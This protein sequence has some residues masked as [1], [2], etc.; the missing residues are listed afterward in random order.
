MVLHVAVAIGKFGRV[1]LAELGEDRAHGLLEEIGQHVE[2]SAVG[3]AHDDFP[4]AQ[5]RAAGE[6]RLQQRHE[7]LAA[8]ERKPLLAD[9]ARVQKPLEP[10]GGE[11]VREDLTLDGGVG[12]GHF[13]PGLDAFAHPIAHVRGGD[14]HELRADLAGVDP[15]ERGEHFPQ[16]HGLAAHEEPRRDDLVEVRSPRIRARPGPGGAAW[17]RRAGA[18]R[19][20]RAYDRA[21][22]RP[23]RHHRRGPGGRDRPRW[24]TGKRGA[25]AAL[26]PAVAARGGVA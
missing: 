5:R 14:V 12:G 23:P 21:C 3:H 1:I 8:F 2:P 19:A 24:R 17:A 22:G 4:D 26:P 11:Q 18:G 13:R 9:V 25:A 7:R 6:D 16:A 15:L 20:G 10:L